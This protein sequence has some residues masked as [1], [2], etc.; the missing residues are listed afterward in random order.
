MFKE[1]YLKSQKSKGRKVFKTVFDKLD[2]MIKS[3]VVDN[4]MQGST[5]VIGFIAME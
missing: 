3:D 1:Q 2:T 5:A 4:L